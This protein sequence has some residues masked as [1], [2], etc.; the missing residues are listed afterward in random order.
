MA[1]ALVALAPF[2]W[3]AP[4]R[5]K[6]APVGFVRVQ[7]VAGR[8]A[9]AVGPGIWTTVD[10]GRVWRR[11]TPPGAGGRLSSWLLSALDA[12]DAWV[13][14]GSASGPAETLFVTEDGGRRWHAH[15]LPM[16]GALQVDMVT[17]RV[18]YLV[19]EPQ[20]GA[21]GTTWYQLWRTADG[22]ST[23]SLAASDSA[24]RTGLVAPRPGQ[25]SLPMGF[26]PVGVAFLTPTRGFI[27]QLFTAR[28]GDACQVTVDGGRRWRGVRLPTPPSLRRVPAY[29]EYVQW[30]SAPVVVS[31]RVAYLTVAFA[32]TEAAAQG[33][34]LYR[35]ADGGARWR[36]VHWWRGD[37]AGLQPFWSF[38]RLAFASARTGWAFDPL[39]SPGAGAPVGAIVTNDGGVVW[40]PASLPEPFT[41]AGPPS[42]TTG[43]RCGLVLLEA[44]GRTYLAATTDQGRTWQLLRPRFVP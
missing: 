6:V 24:S 39:T 37:V 31:P 3:A 26:G 12:Q 5:A 8:A 14:Y 35:S 17:R 13:A 20:G 4:L 2:A 38:V 7:M 25:P 16:Q 28:G 9:W 42:F 22:G 29:E 10:G 1:V 41:P 23:W 44:R 34:A 33:V 11:R 43:G 19:N 36:L 15:A 18:G 40:R 32:P 27:C 30:G 21:M